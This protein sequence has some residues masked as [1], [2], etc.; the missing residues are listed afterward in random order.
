MSPSRA[1]AYARAHREKFLAEL[2][3]F[4][5]FPTVS[6]Q[7]KHEGDIKNCANWLARHLRGIG[8]KDVRI[9]PTPRHPLVYASW[10]GAPHRPTLLIYG[11]YDVQPVDPLD[12]WCSPPFEP[13][14]RGADLFGRGA[15]DDKGQMF[16][17]VKALDHI[18]GRRAH[19]RSTSNAFLKVKKR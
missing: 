6:A 19:C 11:H 14:V 16:T 9:I 2:M 10:R 12:E 1:I 13:I 8:A 17:H 3:D 4:V 15:C 18:C 5:R 7:P